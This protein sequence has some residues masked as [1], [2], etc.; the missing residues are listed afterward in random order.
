MDAIA[1]ELGLDRTEVRSRNF[2]LPSE[3]PYDHGLLFQDGRPLKYDSGDFPASLA[4]IKALVG[5]DDFAAY[6][7]AAEAEGRRVGL[8]IGCYVEGTGVGPYEGGHIQIETSGRV[9]VSTG[10]TSQGQGHE[11]VFAQIVAQE[12]GVRLEDV[13][14]TTGDTR[15]MAYAV[16]TFASRAAVMSGSAIALA[17]RNVRAKALRIAA[18]ALE[19]SPHDLEIVD[20][21]VRVKGGAGDV[22]VARHGVGAVQPAALRVRRGGPGRNAVRRHVRPRQA[23]GRRRR[24]ARPRGARLL[25]PHP[26]DLRQRHARGHRRDRPGDGR[27]PHPALLRRARLRHDDQPD[28]RRGPGARR[29]RA[30]RRRRALRADGLRR[31]GPAAQ[32]VVHGLPRALRLRGAD[33]RDRPP[34]DPVT[35]QPLGHQGCRRG[36]VHPGV[37]RHRLGDRG[38]RGLPDLAHADL[39]QRPVGP[40]PPARR[41]RDP[42]TAPR[43]PHRPEGETA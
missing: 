43:D 1:D 21:T 18:D 30:G 41:R 2:I 14:V 32:R 15:K 7:A 25:L 39:A 37:G 42:V 36:R 6:R 24:R 34:R 20:G 19:V 26:G 33:D 9:N 27:D 4:K 11:T 23:P 31:V 13:H 3:M 17:A 29:R 22:D 10:L 40:A 8:G 38:R 35:P 16:G 12:L 5:W 28:D